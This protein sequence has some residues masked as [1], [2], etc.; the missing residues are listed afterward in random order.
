MKLHYSQTLCKIPTNTG[1]FNTLWNYTT[2]KQP[3]PLMTASLVL[4]PYEI[5]L[6]SN[7]CFLY[8]VK[9]GVLIPYEITLLSNQVVVI[10][11]IGVSFNT[12]WNYTTLKLVVGYW[13]NIA[14]FN[15]LWNYTTL[16][17]WWVSF[18]SCLSFNTLWNYTTLKQV[19]TTC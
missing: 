12:L 19:A 11:L 17:L 7:I 10:E 5:T 9:A 13:N 16:K 14:C 15:T 18:F 4:I 1:S 3:E 2:L 8:F 6:L